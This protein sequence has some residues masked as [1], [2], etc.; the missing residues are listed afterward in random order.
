MSEKPLVRQTL[1]LRDARKRASSKPMQ[2]SDDDW[3]SF[4]A[5]LLPKRVYNT[6][7]FGSNKVDAIDKAI[8]KEELDDT[9]YR[10][11][12]NKAAGPDGIHA[13]FLKYLPDCNRDGV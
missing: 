7:T 11:G 6:S 1:R 9:L 10:L 8:K 13:E 5:K 4:Y 3:L 12:R 2:V